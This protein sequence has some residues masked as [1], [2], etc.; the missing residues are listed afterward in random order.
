MDAKITRLNPRKLLHSKWTAVTPARREKHFL[1]TAVLEP[2]S[3]TLP[4]EFIDLEAVHS[5]KTRRVR[6]RELTDT[7]TWRQGWR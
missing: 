6:W 3:P 4:I 7:A 2:D 1:V 5:K